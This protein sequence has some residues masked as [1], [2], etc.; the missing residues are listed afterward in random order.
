MPVS[1]VGT[2]IHGTPRWNVAATNPATSVAAPPPS[3]TT[4][5]PRSSPNSASRVHAWRATETVLADSPAGSRTVT[6]GSNGCPTTRSTSRS[7]TSA[8]RRAPISRGSSAS[9]ACLAN[10][11][12]SGSSPTKP[13]ASTSASAVSW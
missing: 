13:S 12:S 11:T 8:G 9:A 10:G 7:A 6:N 2:A 4:T 1:E 3:P 5:S